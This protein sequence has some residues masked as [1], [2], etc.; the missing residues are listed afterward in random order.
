MRKLAV[1]LALVSTALG[2]PALARDDAH[3]VRVESRAM[4][5]EDTDYDT[6]AV[7][8]AAAVDHRA[9]PLP[10]S[11]EV[12]CVP[13]PYIVFFDWDE[14]DITQEA[15]SILDNAITNYRSCGNAPV[16][17]AGYTDT[18]GPADYN[19]KLSQRRADSVKA[20][21]T[22][23]GIPGGVVATEAFGE[24]RLRVQTANNVRELQNRRVEITYGSGP[25][26]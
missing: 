17:V 3:Y 21:F 20:Y 4:L 11:P 24:T 8:N 22:G 25:G 13:G 12:V 19:M 14:Y 5:V 10:P 2:T 7:D 9:G 18:S 6:G 26:I 1:T 15:A 16:M 23:R